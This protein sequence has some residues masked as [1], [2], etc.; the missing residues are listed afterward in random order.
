MGYNISDEGGQSAGGGTASVDVWT[1]TLTKG[2]GITT[3]GG[4][5]NEAPIGFAPI[6]ES[7]GLNQYQFFAPTGDFASAVTLNVAGSG[8]GPGTNSDGVY[9]FTVDFSQVTQDTVVEILVTGRRLDE[10]GNVVFSDT[11]TIRIELLICVARGTL[12]DTPR[13]RIPVERLRVGQKVRLRDGRREPIRWIGSRKL[14]RDELDAAPHLC[15]IRIAKDAFGDAMP[16]R[17]LLVSPQHR[18]LVEGWKAE[19]FFG[20]H[21]VLAPARG[22]VNG[23]T[24]RVDA[25]LAEVEYFHLMFARHEIMVTNNL[26]TESF[27][28]GKT[29]L[30][31]IAD[32]ARAELFEIFPKLR[33]EVASYG[34]LA[35]PGLRTWEARVLH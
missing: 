24:V 31:G 13:G 16:D 4:D 35:E 11:D 25:D 17:D 20:E 30:D 3:Q 19:L 14:T 8:S 5:F 10:A 12:I 2:E 15:P 1:F 33:D 34:C 28:P 22:L 32:A 18:V 26:P 23:R 27:F 29:S 6:D 21:E 9:S 7:L